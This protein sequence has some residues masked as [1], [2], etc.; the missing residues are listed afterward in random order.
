MFCDLAIPGVP[1]KEEKTVLG[2]ISAEGPPSDPEPESASTNTHFHSGKL[3]HWNRPQ[4]G[5]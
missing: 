1:R 4:S 3:D 5:L 2:Q